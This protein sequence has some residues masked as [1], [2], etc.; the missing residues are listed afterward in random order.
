VL[1]AAATAT[2]DDRLRRTLI[3]A[4]KSIHRVLPPE[5]G[6]PDVAADGAVTDHSEPEETAR[7]GVLER[8]TVVGWPQSETGEL[9]ASGQQASSLLAG[10]ARVLMAARLADAPQ[11]A[12][13]Q[14]LLVQA[15][16]LAAQI[17]RTIAARQDATEAQRRAAAAVARAAEAAANRP[18]G[19]QFTKTG[20]EV[21][22]AA[23]TAQAAGGEHA[24]DGPRPAGPAQGPE[25][26]VRDT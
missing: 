12:R 4:W 1:A 3:E 7:I 21:I 25:Q 26:R 6:A 17:S 20:A 10:V 24:T 14:A 5:A 8:G 19:W 22:E 9:G 13:V 2:T 23:R 16:Q 18:G 11:H 15:V